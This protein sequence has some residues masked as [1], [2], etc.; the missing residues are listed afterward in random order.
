[1][2][3]SAPHANSFDVDEIFQDPGFSRHVRDIMVLPPH[4]LIQPV[5]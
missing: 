1:M 2:R 4:V 3:V 5:F